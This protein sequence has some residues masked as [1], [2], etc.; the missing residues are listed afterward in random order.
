MTSPFSWT[1]LKCT[2]TAAILWLT[3]NPPILM[4]DF[5]AVADTASILSKRLLD[6]MRV[7]F[8]VEVLHTVDFVA[9]V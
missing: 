2:R 7:G 8:G 5:E 3:I 1:V 4:P 9:A 6:G